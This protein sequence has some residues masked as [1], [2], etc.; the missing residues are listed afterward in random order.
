MT[1]AQSYKLLYNGAQTLG[2]VAIFVISALHFA[3]GGAPDALYPAI[4]QWLVIF[5]TLA[6]LEIVH[7]LF[8]IVRSP[9]FSTFVQVMSR[10][11]VLHG[12]LQLH[13]P[14]VTSHWSVASLVFSWSAVEVIRYSYY[15]F[16]ELN[17]VPYLL[18]WLRYSAFM[19]LYPSGISSELL[20]LY[21]SLSSLRVYRPFTVDLPNVVNFAFD[22]PL[23][24][25]FLIYVV[26]APGSVFMYTHMLQQRKKQLGAAR[27][28]SL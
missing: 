28:K 22:Y 9:V 14:E 6:I 1:V 17:S 16:N 15:F 24:V 8:G 19:V 2:W 23:I 10:I 18:K 13:Y 26:Y 27:Q 4:Q 25:T 12:A 11:L 5:Q 3:A 21:G 7:S 20:I